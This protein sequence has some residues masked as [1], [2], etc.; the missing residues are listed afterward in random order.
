M[1]RMLWRSGAQGWGASSREACPRWESKG[2]PDRT[3][4]SGHSGPKIASVIGM[5]W[6]A[7]VLTGFFHFPYIT[8]DWRRVSLI[9][10]EHLQRRLTLDLSQESWTAEHH[11]PRM[12]LVAA[13]ST[14][15][16]LFR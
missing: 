5:V 2:L 1:N 3:G 13:S 7:A 10:P 15:L 12:T 11:R 8:G 4:G 16:W 14:I 9:A 6:Q